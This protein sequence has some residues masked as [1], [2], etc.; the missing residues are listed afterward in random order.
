MIEV[1]RLQNSYCQLLNPLSSFDKNALIKDTKVTHLSCWMLIVNDE[2]LCNKIKNF[3][4]E[5]ALPVHIRVKYQEKDVVLSEYS[6]LT[7]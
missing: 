1:Q 6:N 4:S 5:D 7:V 3:T 2:E